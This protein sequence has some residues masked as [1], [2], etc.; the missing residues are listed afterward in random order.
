MRRRRA[1]DFKQGC[2]LDLAGAAETCLHTG[3]RFILI[4][5]MTDEFPCACGHGLQQLMQSRSVERTGG[6]DTDGAM[7][8]QQAAASYYLLKAAMLGAQQGDLHPSREACVGS[9]FQAPRGFEGVADTP[10]S[11]GGCGRKK[12]SQ[13]AGK[14]VRV[15]VRIDMRDS[16]AGG[17]HAC[18]LRGCFLF[19]LAGLDLAAHECLD[20]V[21]E[22]GPKAGRSG[23]GWDLP[24]W[25][26]RRAIDQDDVAADVERGLHEGCVHGIAEG[27]AGGHEG[28]R[29]QRAGSVQFED[30]VV[31]A[32]SQTEIGGVDN[33]SRTLF[34]EG[35]AQRVHR[36]KCSKSG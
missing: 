3:K 10:D 1:E 19:D 29:G 36:A 35:S 28:R 8:R 6:Q 5:G 9:C 27:C 21:C 12:G 2:S 23:E 34:R 4:A 20:E 33:Q 15:F 13:D 14:H 11:G 26:D 22:C 30:G 24:V 16:E 17:L 31:D 18:N 32:I 7:C 25:Q